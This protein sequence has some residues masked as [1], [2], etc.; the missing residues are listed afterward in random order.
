MRFHYLFICTTLPILPLLALPKLGVEDKQFLRELPAKQRAILKQLALDF[1]RAVEQD[2]DLQAAV[3]ELVKPEYESLALLLRQ[4]P[5]FVQFERENAKYKT[6]FKLLK[7]LKLISSVRDLAKAHRD[8]RPSFKAF[9]HNKRVKSAFAKLAA[10][11]SESMKRC[12]LFDMKSLSGGTSV[13]EKAM[14]LL[15]K[16]LTGLDVELGKFIQV[17]AVDYTVKKFIHVNKLLVE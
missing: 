1:R 4:I 10:L 15:G 12:Y 14:G 8:I 7:D 3:A 11:G 6:I 13:G 9:I 2:A 16:Y 17:V 5:E